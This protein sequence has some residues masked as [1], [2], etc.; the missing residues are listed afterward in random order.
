MKRSFL[1]WTKPCVAAVFLAVAWLAGTTF[2][3]CKIGSDSNPEDVW[4]DN[5]SNPEDP[6]N[7]DSSYGQ[8]TCTLYFHPNAPE[9]TSESEAPAPKTVTVDIGNYYTIPEE[10]IFSFDGYYFSGW[11]Q[12]Y[13]YTYKPGEKIYISGELHLY[14]IWDTSTY[15]NG[16]HISKGRVV[17]YKADELP[18]DVV[19]PDGVTAIASKAFYDIWEKTGC[20][21]IKSI[22]I[23]A[24][25][26]SIGGYAFEDCTNLEKVVIEG[27]PN[28]I[29]PKTFAGCVSLKSIELPDSVK[30]IGKYAFEHCTSLESVIMNG[31]KTI[32][33]LAFQ[34]CKNLAFV[35]MNSVER[36]EEWAFIGSG[37]TNVSL[38]T[39]LKFIGTKAFSGCNFESI[40]IP[41]NIDVENIGD[42]PFNSCKKLKKVVLPDNW[43]E[44]KSGMF[45]NC[46]SLTD[47]KF[48]SVLKIIGESAFYGCGFTE[49]I[50]PDGVQEIGSHAFSSCKKLSNVNIPD[51]VKTIGR[52]AFWRSPLSEIIIPEN[53]TVE[54][55]AFSLSTNLRTISIP[56]SVINTGVKFWDIFT[57]WID[58]LPGNFGCP[59]LQTPYPN[60]PNNNRDTYH[61]FHNIDIILREGATSI[62]KEFMYNGGLHEFKSITIPDSM[63]EIED[64]A[65]FNVGFETVTIPTD[66][67][68]EKYA[69]GHS[70]VNAFKRFVHFDGTKAQYE[71]F[72]KYTEEVG[73]NNLFKYATIICKDGT[74]E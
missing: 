55:E 22:T 13:Y 60:Y 54:K 27:Q 2:T 53:A 31:V 36:L 6:Y 40:T 7:P 35:A 17:G 68:V 19:I 49:V 9:G 32:N 73:G 1:N 50:I 20:D 43:N 14:A 41:D 5:N 39:T 37:L 58:A 8:T 56:A 63:K 4:Y 18:A 70:F 57:T 71:K 15:I 21:I 67:I 30:S 47:V 72:L 26:Q 38:P 33:S 46:E 61:D 16:L 59:E 12:G 52:D 45:S 28:E 65:F 74:I 44:I 24:S 11:K 34:G 51:S 3:G 10:T 42:A 23:P 66:L 25:V 64:S 29:E 62:P 69:F 48:P